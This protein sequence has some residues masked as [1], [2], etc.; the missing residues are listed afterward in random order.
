MS[1]RQVP[2]LGIF[3]H[4]ERQH[5]IVMI[6]MKGQGFKGGSI[7]Q[8]FLVIL[9]EFWE[10]VTPRSARDL[11]CRSRFSDDRVVPHMDTHEPLR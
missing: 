5:F 10:K 8:P 2:F 7:H 3:A 9:A 11:T 4:N 1:L 6:E